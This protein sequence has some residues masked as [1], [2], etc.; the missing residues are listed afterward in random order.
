[1]KIF[2]LRKKHFVSVTMYSTEMFSRA[3]QVCLIPYLTLLIMFNRSDF[4]EC[5]FRS[6]QV[7]SIGKVYSHLIVL[8][9][10]LGTRSPFVFYNTCRDKY[11][12]YKRQNNSP[13]EGRVSLGATQ[14]N[15]ARLCIS[16]SH[17]AD[18]ISWLAAFFSSS[19]FLAWRMKTLALSIFFFAMDI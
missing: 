12:Y 10:G 16:Q 9:V 18:I 6:S 15:I 19:L 1:M 7:T 4:K 13:S 3:T 8:K 5:S 14:L 11:M 2:I 17:L